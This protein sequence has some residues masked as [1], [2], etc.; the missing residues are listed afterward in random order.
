M[1]PRKQ[2]TIVAIVVIITTVAVVRWTVLNQQKARKS[3]LPI[4]WENLKYVYLAISRYREFH[5][6]LPYDER[7]GDYALF[8]LKNELDESRFK[9][10]NSGNFFSGPYWDHENERLVESDFEYLNDPTGKCGPYQIMLVEKQ[11]ADEADHVLVCLGR[12][13]VRRCRPTTPTPAG[14]LG[15]YAT[16]D[17]FWIEDADVYELWESIYLYGDAEYQFTNEDGRITRASKGEMHTDYEYENGVITAR[18]WATPNGTIRDDIETNELG[19]IVR[20]RRTPENWRD[21]WRE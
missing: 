17:G 7:G 3:K 8:K 9:A 1:L 18:I 14:M 13:K 16:I 20:V 11:P 5:G 19:K 4:A 15:Y 6:R 21:I 2:S 10:S 12:G